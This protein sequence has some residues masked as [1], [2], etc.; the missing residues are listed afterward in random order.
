MNLDC[1]CSVRPLRS[2]WR[3]LP[4]AGPAQDPRSRQG[5]NTHARIAM[6]NISLRLILQTVARPGC[7]VCGRTDLDWLRCQVLGG[8]GLHGLGLA[9]RER[10]ALGLLLHHHERVGVGISKRLHL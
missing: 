2:S 3:K 7:D 6:Y 8:P 4:D 1:I 10:R 5:L 9:P